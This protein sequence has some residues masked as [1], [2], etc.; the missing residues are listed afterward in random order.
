L[1]E[2]VSVVIDAYL[3]T[4]EHSVPH[5]LLV[6]GSWG[7]GKTYFLKE[8][9]KDR[10]SRAKNTNYQAP[11]LF[12]SLYGATSAIDAELKIHRAAMPVEAAIFGGVDTLGTGFFEAFKIKDGY[13]RFQKWI[14]LKNARRLGNYIFVFDD[15]ERVADGSLDEIMGL[16]NTFVTQYDRRV[17][18]VTDET[19]LVENHTKSNWKD[20]NEKIIGRRARITADVQSVVRVSVAKISDPETKKFM[21]ERLQDLEVLALLSGVQNLRNLVWAIHNAATFVGCILPDPDVPKDHVA[22]TMAVVAAT[23]LWIR[24]GKLSEEVIKMLPNLSMTL[25][26]R[27][28][29]NRREAKPEDSVLTSARAFSETFNTIRVDQPPVAYEFI[30]DYE[31][32]GV[33]DCRAVLDWVKAQFGFGENY[34]E[35]AWKVIWLIS[36]RTTDEA[37]AAITRLA[38][39]LRDRKHDKRVDIL[40]AAGVTI[41]LSDANDVRVTGGQDVVSFFKAYI[42][43]LVLDHRLQPASRDS[44]DYDLEAH[45]GYEYSSKDTDEFKAISAYLLEKQQEEGSRQLHEQAEALIKRAEDGDYEVLREFA[46]TDGGEIS[47][48]PVLKEF[49]VDRIV[50]LFVR[51][52]KFLTAGREVLS[53]RHLHAH[54]ESLLLEEIP[55]AKK[56]YANVLQQLANWPDP[57]STLAQRNW[58]GVIGYYDGRRIAQARITGTKKDQGQDGAADGGAEAPA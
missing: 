2:Q 36:E 38:V 13:A 54:L 19:R 29:N 12:I 40:H 31:K 39:E 18:L 55:W 49:E 50:Q 28:M 14:S 56:V 57:H 34:I 33:T 10:E 11:F 35:P 3:D 15:L 16:V 44:F 1:N 6:E 43:D 48:Y 20:Q 42:D 24:S 53:Y 5:A 58:A 25:M 27:D 23:T 37:E 51:D 21:T 4:K 7:S 46:R 52:T 9:A 26:V 47:K 45:G 41:K 32:S 17:I 30:T 22:R 8:Y